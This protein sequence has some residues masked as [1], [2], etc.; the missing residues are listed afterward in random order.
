MTQIAS[1]MNIDDSSLISAEGNVIRSSAG[2]QTLVADADY[3]VQPTDNVI[4]YSS[5]TASRTL[6]FTPQGTPQMLKIWHVKDISLNCSVTKQINLTGAGGALFDGLAIVAISTPGGSKRF[7]DDGTKFFM[8]DAF[9]PSVYQSTKIQ[10][11]DGSGGF[12]DAISGTDYLAPGYL[13]LRTTSSLSLSLVG[14]GATGTQ[15]SSTKDST[16]RLTV[17]TSATATIAGAATSLVTLKICATNNTTEGSWT[18]VGVSETDQS[19]SLA[20]ALQ[21]VTAGKGVLAAD[22]PAGWWAKLVNTGT[23]TH[24]ESFISGQQTIYG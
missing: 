17:S 3:T 21:G 13:P 4:C 15:I 12:L 9:L 1:G 11:A 7:F 18:T 5:L 16:I 14:T 23:G 2:Y 24:A 8:G 20:V 10:K 6:T 22:I 19:Y